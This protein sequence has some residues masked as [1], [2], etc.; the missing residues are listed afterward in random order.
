ME[1]GLLLGFLLRRNGSL[2][3]SAGLEGR[4]G[5]RSNLQRFAGLGVLA[6]TR[7]ALGGF[8]GTET[9]Q[10]DV[11]TLGDRRGDD[12]DQRIDGFAGG[13]LGN[14]S[15]GCQRCNQ[16]GFVHWAVLP[17]VVKE[18]I[19]PLI[20]VV[21][22][23]LIAQLCQLVARAASAGTGSLEDPAFQQVSDVAQRSVLRTLAY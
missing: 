21:A 2:E 9:D 4:N 14:F 15:L 11:V 1:A 10:S 3:A 8:E 19:L 20:D 22:E 6:G 13:C 23:S 5:R 17:W 7:G 12:L 18:M 16:L